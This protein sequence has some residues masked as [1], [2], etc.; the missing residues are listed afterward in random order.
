MS[1]GATGTT[2]SGSSKPGKPRQALHASDWGHIAMSLDLRGIA[3]WQT[4]GAAAGSRWP[5]I[6][7]VFF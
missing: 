5:S 6:I 1:D 4:T 3:R 2:I 7:V